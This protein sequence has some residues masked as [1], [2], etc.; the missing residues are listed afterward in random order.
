MIY[1]TSPYRAH[2]DTKLDRNACASLALLRRAVPG[3]DS[4][5]AVDCKTAK[6]DEGGPSWN[7][8][9]ETRESQ[10]SVSCPFSSSTTSFT[11]FLPSFSST[12]RRSPLTS[13][14]A[15]LSFSSFPPVRHS[16]LLVLFGSRSL[17]S[18][19]GARRA[20]PLPLSIRLEL[21]FAFLRFSL[22]PRASS[23]EAAPSVFN[24]R[25]CV[26]DYDFF[27]VFPSY[28]LLFYLFSM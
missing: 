28:N 23:C 9:A 21:R 24:Y 10:R 15:H 22:Q 5:D 4:C 27:P 13:I 19:S 16:A 26:I 18:L 25:R 14:P 20:S 1:G 8:L 11:S 17:R 2:N 3:G 7:S 12:I 6:E